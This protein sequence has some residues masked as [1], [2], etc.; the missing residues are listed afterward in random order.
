MVN[1]L[2][3][4]GIKIT[5]TTNGSADVKLYINQTDFDDYNAAVV[6]SL[7]ITNRSW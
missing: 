5:P 2:Q 6:L 7:T 4:A 3:D 1:L